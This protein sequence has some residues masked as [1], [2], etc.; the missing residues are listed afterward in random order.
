MRQEK[1]KVVEM[2]RKIDDLQGHIHQVEEE[3]SLLRDVNENFG[4][5]SDKL[6]EEIKILQE[7][8]NRYCQFRIPRTLNP[9]QTERPSKRLKSR[10]ESPNENNAEAARVRFV[11]QGNLQ[12]N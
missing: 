12:L 9:S 3:N 2:K 10:E 6:H 4:T 1:F 5:E 11:L 7:K 8:L